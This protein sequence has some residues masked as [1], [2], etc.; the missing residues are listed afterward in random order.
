MPGG[1]AEVAGSDAVPPVGWG[2]IAETG[3]AKAGWAAVAAASDISGSPVD[4]AVE[5]VDQGDVSNL[6]LAV[7]HDGEEHLLD[8]HEHGLPQHVFAALCG[9]RRWSRK[10]LMDIPRRAFWRFRRFLDVGGSASTA[11]GPSHGPE[12]VGP[13]AHEPVDPHS[14]D[15][16]DVLGQYDSVADLCAVLEDLPPPLLGIQQAGHLATDGP[17]VV[18]TLATIL[19]QQ[20]ALVLAHPEVQLTDEDHCKAIQ[21]FLREKDHTVGL[22]AEST[23]LGLDPRMVQV[24]RD[25]SAAGGTILWRRDA[26]VMISKFTSDVVKAGGRA[27]LL[28][29][30]L[31]YDETPMKMRLTDAERSSSFLRK[32]SATPSGAIGANRELETK[33][34]SVHVAKVL[35]TMRSSRLLYK[36]ATGEYVVL[37]VDIP[38][39]LQSLGGGTSGH[40]MKALG[41][42]EFWLPPSVTT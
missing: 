7:V 23:Y 24:L 38:C 26:A 35:Q 12:D 4:A 31:R 29:S 1:W 9:V 22:I 27:I 25:A 18:G 2:G 8:V 15:E 33:C 42:T 11:A 13:M 41:A 5:Q 3:S 39:W 37:H 16:G 6:A 36:T 20:A 17:S 19:E 14:D 30:E 10:V 21:Y 34:T 28:T 40:Y 32:A